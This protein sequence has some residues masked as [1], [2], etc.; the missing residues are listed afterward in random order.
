MFLKLAHTKTEVFAVSKSLVLEVYRVSRI[1]PT[2]ERF[3]LVQQLRRAVVS[4]QL[5]LA[6]GCSRKSAAER[7]RFY[8]VARGSLIEVDTAIGIAYELQYCTLEQLQSLGTLI[9]LTFKQLCGLI[10][11]V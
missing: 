3:A 9:V 8:E 5:N 10:N 4:V 6:E 2:E 7:K 1:F 11:S